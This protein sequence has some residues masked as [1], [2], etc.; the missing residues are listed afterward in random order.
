MKRVAVGLVVV[1]ALAA[2][3]AVA[4][5]KFATFN[6]SLHRNNEGDLLADLS[7]STINNRIRQIRTVAEIIQR[8]NPDVLLINEFDYVGSN[9]AVDLF[10]NKF[11]AMP[12][13]TLNTGSPAAAVN[14][15][16]RLAFSSNTGIASGFDLDN[17]GVVVTTP[18]TAGYGDDA[19][20][21]GDFPGQFGFAVFSKYPLD[22]ASIRTFQNFKWKDMPGALLTS[23]AVLS[24][25]YSDEEKAILRLSSKNHV[26][27]PIDI[28]GKRIHLLAS[29]PT[30]PVFDGAEDRNGK[31]NHDETRF[32][33]DYITPGADGY[34][35]DDAGGIGG[36]AS[37]ESFII[38]GDLNADYFDGDSHNFAIRQLLDD[39][40]INTSA[41]PSSAGGAQQSALQGGVN[42][43]HLGNPLFDT[44]DFSEF[45]AGNLRSDY[46]LP[47]ADLT[48]FDSGIFWP[49]STDPYFRLVG[50]VNN[51]NYF[52]G[53][54]SSDHR[55]VYV[56]IP[57][58]AGL[59]LIALILMSLPRR[60]P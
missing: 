19:F 25:F 44:A 35:Y 52:N 29:H 17:N 30:P 39:P 41:T 5:V 20:G 21:F 28:G 55:L 16:Y 46:V 58:P 45:G 47:S 42:N 8:V 60:R 43:Q 32:W 40:M 38:A 22:P 57:E 27:V 59:A 1:A 10:Q 53:F 12:Q 9:Q 7:S 6:A 26:D 48:I 15:P 3:Q 2:S 11:L 34:I 14:Y 54:P 50:T 51:P 56:T 13:D 4:Q 31:R 24:T 33:K 18:E 37:G 23:D 36:L 49:L